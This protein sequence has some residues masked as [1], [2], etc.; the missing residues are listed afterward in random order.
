MIKFANKTDSLTVIILPSVVERD[1]Q[2]STIKTL[3]EI[4]TF[5]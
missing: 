4:R 3:H 1:A 2:H 5:L